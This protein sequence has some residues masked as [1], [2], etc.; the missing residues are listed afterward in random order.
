MWCLV[1][2]LLMYFVC[3]R[4][5][6]LLIFP[7]SASL[8]LLVDHR[9]CHRLILTEALV[10]FI[11]SG[12]AFTIVMTKRHILVD[13]NKPSASKQSKQAASTN[14]ELCVLC[15]TETGESLQ[16]PLRST[17]RNPS[18]AVMRPWQ[19]TFFR[20]RTFSTCQRISG[21]RDWT[22]VMVWKTP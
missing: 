17:I 5:S 16:C 3:C 9:Y 12:T 18:V 7:R 15:Q 1:L 22:M 8:L 19:R 10:R 20:S 11:I 2:T 6:L 14:W 21:W 13:P 4:I